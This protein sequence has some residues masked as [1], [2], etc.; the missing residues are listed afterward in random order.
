[1]LRDCARRGAT[2]GSSE[3]R[4][5][6]K[7]PAGGR[8]PQTT[9]NC[10]T[11]LRWLTRRRS[12]CRRSTKMKLRLGGILGCAVFGALYLTRPE[13]FHTPTDPPSHLIDGIPDSVRI[14]PVQGGERPARDPPPTAEVAVRRPPP[15][16]AEPVY[17][18]QVSAPKDYRDAVCPAFV[19]RIRTEVPTLPNTSVVFCFCNEPRSSLYHSIHSVIDRTPR[20][21]LHEIILV[22]DGSSAPHLAK[23]LEDYVATLPVPVHIVRQGGRTGLMKARVA[24]ARRA[25]GVTLTFLDSHIDC[26]TDWAEPL[27]W[28]TSQDLYFL[29]LQ[30]QRILFV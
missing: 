9:A 20:H 30:S 15:P 8:A 24:G 1:M 27:M 25:S 29:S 7:T 28:V 10:H 26:S 3:A 19:A 6:H 16:P 12:V 18:E 22:D 23:P 11:L 5:S 2:E 13:L 17:K 14:K 4:S 21:I